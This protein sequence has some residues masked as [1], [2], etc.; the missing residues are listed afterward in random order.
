MIVEKFEEFNNQ[1]KSGLLYVSEHLGNVYRYLL[2]DQLYIHW[3]TK[4]ES[5]PDTLF[6][7][8]YSFLS[9]RKPMREQLIYA[10]DIAKMKKLG[11]E[12]KEAKT[13][14]RNKRYSPV[15]VIIPDL[16]IKKHKDHYMVTQAKDFVDHVIVNLKDY[17]ISNVEIGSDGRLLSDWT[18]DEFIDK[19]GSPIGI[20]VKFI[21][22]LKK[23]Q[24]FI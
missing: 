22:P 4:R 1:K 7:E 9:Y 12:I 2:Q 6:A 21:N 19:Y 16:Y 3:I 11:F 24:L 17:A 18:G 13:D 15:E 20:T 10:L 8:T 14:V 5:P 23:G